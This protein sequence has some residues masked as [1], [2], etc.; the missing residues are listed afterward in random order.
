MDEQR[1]GYRPDARNTNHV[2]TGV[3]RHS[4]QIP[5]EAWEDIDTLYLMKYLE[6]YYTLT[7]F[8]KIL[9]FVSWNI[10]DLFKLNKF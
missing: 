3:Q 6:S 2:H 4:S 10:E 9:I 5:G 1:G 7:K 8:L